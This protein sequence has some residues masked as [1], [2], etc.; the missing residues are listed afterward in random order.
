MIYS[1]TVLI[2]GAGASKPYGMPLGTGLRDEIIRNGLFFKVDFLECLEYS[3]FSKEEYK[4]FVEDLRLSG[5]PSVDLYLE[6]RDKY[7]DIGKFSI[8]YQILIEQEKAL[9][10]IFPP[11]QPKDHWLE[12]LWLKLLGDDFNDFKKNNL[13]ILTFNYDRLVDEYLTELTV[14]HFDGNTFDSHI[15]I[16]HLHGAIDSM[17]D[18]GN[19]NEVVK[20]SK[21]SIK[22]ISESNA[23]TPEFERATKILEDSEKILF[24]GFGY[25]QTNLNKFNFFGLKLNK[26]ENKLMEIIAGTHKGIKSSDWNNICLV[27]G[28]SKIAR[29]TGSGSISEFLNELLVF[30]EFQ[31]M[32]ARLM[33]R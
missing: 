10:N 32:S 18:F 30:E 1:K 6:K 11:F 17:F 20:K 28:F 2:I 29:R 12:V 31:A 3:G 8:A 33:G 19:F 14:N 15:E 27:N 22:I 26:P 5:Y 13:K 25:N 9:K 4:D 7:L 16:I 23:S 21:D 24:L